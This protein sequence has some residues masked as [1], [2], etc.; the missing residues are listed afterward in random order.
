M[1]TLI[2]SQARLARS[3][4]E[5]DVFAVGD[6]EMLKQCAR[7]LCDNAAKYTPEGGTIRLRAKKAGRTDG[8]LI[9]VQD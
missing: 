7:M 8:S 5:P 2:D 6:H 4:T 3:D 1:A 9:E